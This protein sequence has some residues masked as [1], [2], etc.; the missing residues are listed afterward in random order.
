MPCSCVGR[1]SG[2]CLQLSAPPQVFQCKESSKEF[3]F[4]DLNFV[5]LV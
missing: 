2:A 5:P 4:P 1:P 3:R